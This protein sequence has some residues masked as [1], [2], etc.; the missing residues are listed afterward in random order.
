MMAR[1]RGHVARRA[2]GGGR[3][4]T[5]T[6]SA[7]TSTASTARIADQ[8]RLPRRPL[9]DAPRRDG[10]R[11]RRPT[12]PTPDRGRGD[13]RARCTSRSAAG[14]LGFSS[15]L[16][17]APHRRRRRTRCRRVAADRDEF[18]ALAG[19]LPRPRGHDARVH[20]GRR[21][22]H[23]RAHGADGRHVARG[24]PAAQL[25]PARQPVPGRDLRAA[26]AGVRPRGRDR[27]RRSSRS[28]C[29][30]S[31]ACARAAL[32]ETLPGWQEVVRMPDAERRAGGAPIPTRAPAARRRRPMPR[33]TVA[34]RWRDFDLDRD[35]RRPARRGGP[36][37]AEVAARPA[38]C[39]TGRR[40]RRRRAARPPRAH[41]DPAVARADPRRVADEGWE[42]RAAI[43]HDP[44]VCSAVPTPART[45]T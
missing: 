3:R 29:P 19:A 16:G 30:T 20:P 41:A 37:M 32:L 34:R 27:A 17:E 12:R 39:D 42:A 21:R 44:R 5:G 33:D 25:E 15:S 6:R 43:W 31:C 36:S 28:R 24:R 10:R 11:R 7:T 14:A 2:R 1:G 18:L 38:A 26:A 9:D 23:R 4:G 45:S 35:R 40:A 8:R 13:G 22:D